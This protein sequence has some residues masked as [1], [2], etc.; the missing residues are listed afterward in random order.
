[1]NSAIYEIE[2]GN[3]E[4]GGGASKQLKEMLKR[5]GADPAAVRRAMIAAFEAEMNVVIHAGDGVMQIALSPEQV[6]ISVIDQGPGI[7]D[8]AKAL[9]EGFSTAP[10]A[11]RE[12]GFGA[13]MGLPNIR[14]NT[15]RFSI[16]S[17]VGK[18]ACL[19]FSIRLQP[20]ESAPANKAALTVHAEDCRQSLRC[21]HACPA[22]AIRV[23]E[24]RPRILDH[25]CVDCTACAA[26]CPSGV[27]DM[28]CSDALPPLTADTVLLLPPPFLVQFEPI[29]A[30]A[31][32]LR[33][34]NG[35]GFKQ[36]RLFAE[37]ETALR[38]AAL[39]YASEHPEIRPVFAPLCPAVTS[40]IQLRFPS[41]LPH[42]APFLSPVEAVRENLAA[43]HM[44]FVPACPAHTRLLRDPSVMSRIDVVAP[45]AL[46]AAIRP[47]LRRSHRESPGAQ[48]LQKSDV[49][50]VWGIHRAAAFLDRTENGLMQDCG[51][52]ELYACEQ[53]C[54]GAPAWRADPFASRI[55]FER[56]P[57]DSYA[58]TDAPRAAA[59]QRTAELLPRA[60]V[61]LD[62]DMRRAMEKLARIDALNKTLPGRDCGVCG[63][64][65]CSALA[66]DIVMGNASIDDCPFRE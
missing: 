6:D 8:I 7:P 10:P 37:W 53:G 55:R 27:F 54:F 5:L 35:L 56:M 31:D 15:D 12:L 47:A 63:A 9:T 48:A 52:V 39:Q 24:G 28:A 4:K 57:P 20:Q 25:L 45:S 40:L 16:Q 26:A 30:P 62:A 59:I 18:G 34:L 42:I 32:V 44:L 22:R 50:E 23:R 21:V 36:I 46:T 65:A 2:G 13:G 38:R 64:P 43:A 41:L 33:A 51:V 17:E 19:R 66:E 1:M 11:A 14:K 29:T 3:Y 60:G 61:R 49:L 58:V